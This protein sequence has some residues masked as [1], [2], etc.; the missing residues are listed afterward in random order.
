MLPRLVLFVLVCLACFTSCWPVIARDWLLAS[1]ACF[2]SSETEWLR[3]AHPQ[4][5]FV[6]SL[7]PGSPG[8]PKIHVSTEPG[9]GAPLHELNQAQQEEQPTKRVEK[10]KVYQ[11]TLP[12]Q[13]ATLGRDGPAQQTPSPP[14][15]GLPFPSSQR[16]FSL[17]VQAMNP[18][19]LSEP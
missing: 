3:L 14:R 4:K 10:R 19:L 1:P 16:F 15:C 13:C 6:R 17:F 2:R 11:A 18:V 5:R 8:T 12:L 7:E 9:Y